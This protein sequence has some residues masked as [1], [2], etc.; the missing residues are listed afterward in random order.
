MTTKILI[1]LIVLGMNGMSGVL[2]VQ[3]VKE[4]FKTDIGIEIASVMAEI[5]AMDHQQNLKFAITKYANMSKTT[6]SMVLWL[7]TSHI[8]LW[9]R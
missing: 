9:I 1:K 7:M 4:A 5:H 8:G 3:V 6:W 2:A